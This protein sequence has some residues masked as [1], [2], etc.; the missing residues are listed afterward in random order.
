[1]GVRSTSSSRTAG[2]VSTRDQL[3]HNCLGL[4]NAKAGSVKKK[5]KKERKIPNFQKTYLTLSNYNP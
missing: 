1:M 4:S 3:I 2:L 5:K